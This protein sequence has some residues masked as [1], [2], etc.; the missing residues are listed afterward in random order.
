[1]LPIILPIAPAGRRGSAETPTPTPRAIQLRAHKKRIQGINTL[2]PNRRVADERI[3]APASDAAVCAPQFHRV[4]RETSVSLVKHVTIALILREIRVA[5]PAVPAY[6]RS[7]AK[8]TSRGAS[9]KFLH[10]S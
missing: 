6:A 1:M 7:S 8:I 3:S 2:R 5:L 10:R 9:A 4:C